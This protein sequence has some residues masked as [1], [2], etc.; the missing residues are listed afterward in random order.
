MV[1]YFVIYI[2]NNL[3]LVSFLSFFRTL[4][5]I[6][7]STLTSTVKLDNSVH[8]LFNWLLARKQYTYFGN[9]LYST[10][11]VWIGLIH[12][13]LVAY[14]LQWIYIYKM[15]LP[16]ALVFDLWNQHLLYIFLDIIDHAWFGNLTDRPTSTTDNARTIYIGLPLHQA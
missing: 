8:L 14:F 15:L 12:F 4:H 3:T 11:F 6:V 13:L 7:L 9:G 16:Y 5:L 2:D 1:V 10:S